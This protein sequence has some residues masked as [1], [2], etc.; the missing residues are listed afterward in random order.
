MVNMHDESRGGVK[1]EAPLW[2]GVT[3]PITDK[4]PT[5]EA[6]ELSELLTGV[7]H[8]H[9]LFES[10]E[11]MKHRESVL[12]ELNKILAEWIQE[13]AVNA[14]L[15][16]E[17][18]KRSSGR[19]FTFGS[20]RLGIVAPGGDIDTLCVAPRF[21]TRDAFFTD[22]YARLQESPGVSSLQA[23]K[24]AYTPIIKLEFRKVEL[25]LLFAQL[26]FDILPR[27]LNSLDDDELLKFVDEKTAR[28]L[29]GC[30]VAALLLNLVPSVESF[31]ATLRAVKLWA[32]RRGVYSNVLGYLGGV[33]WALL[34]ARVCQLYPNYSCSLLLNRFFRIYM[35]WNWQ[36]PVLLC[37]IEEHQGVPGLANFRVW[38]PQRNQHDKQHLMP[39]I[40]PAFPAMN[41]THNVTHTT[42]RILTDEFRR[43]FEIVESIQRGEADWDTLFESFGLAEQC[44]HVLVLKV[45]A[46]EEDVL[47]RWCGWVK[48][49]LRFLLRKL[50]AVEVLSV[51]PW[52]ISYDTND[53]N[54]GFTSSLF[55]GMDFDLGPP[56]EGY[57]LQID[58]RPAFF[59]FVQVLM[60]WNE[61][62]ECQGKYSLNIEY[63][64]RNS[65]THL[66][67]NQPA[68]MKVLNVMELPM[69]PLKVP[70]ALLTTVTGVG[71]TTTSATGG[72]TTV[73]SGY[74]D[75]PTTVAI[76]TTPMIDSSCSIDDNTPA[77]DF[78]A[79]IGTGIVGTKV[80]GA[81][82]STAAVQ[83]LL[84][85]LRTQTTTS[86]SG[87][88]GVSN[89]FNREG[90]VY[91]SAS[92]KIG[93][94]NPSDQGVGTA[95]GLPNVKST[96]A[97]CPTRCSPV[98][99]S[100]SGM[101]GGSDGGQRER[102]KESESVD[103]SMYANIESDDGL[104][105]RVLAH[106]SLT[107]NNNNNNNNN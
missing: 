49:K 58:L 56:V 105:R 96:T 62:D 9:N 28:S 39:V 34:V 55:L 3:N 86:S 46:S 66:L 24:G 52:P 59:D 90:T 43:A 100:Y 5:A 89:S 85:T 77:S 41:S 38:N 40:T 35:R 78:S 54:L 32:Q 103:G 75:T 73:G 82:N 106:N 69:A 84:D 7:L 53:K 50:E 98:P 17:D 104:N 87:G 64:K 21:V 22:F 60:L 12:L 45:L 71:T 97:R 27:N 31:R 107:N 83:S 37:N 74:A 30:R 99:V 102:H 47:R 93:Q 1:V 63:M 67:R 14:G 4:G 72:S 16:E 68:L 92:S 26:G 51:R 91:E 48:S 19:L 95:S 2:R 65:L 25:D 57:R 15:S 94:A 44:Q 81:H 42:M 80:D 8:K 20:Y 6:I 11:M 13:Q 29:N 10:P 79:G 70:S 23:V 36:H 61:R 18:V 76:D 88:G 101:G 33:S